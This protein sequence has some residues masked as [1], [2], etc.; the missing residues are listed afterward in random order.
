MW[1]QKE[2]SLEI[3]TAMNMKIPCLKIWGEFGRD[4]T[5][6]VYWIVLWA[7]LTFLEAC[8][9]SYPNWLDHLIMLSQRHS[10]L[11]KD[12]VSDGNGEKKITLV[13]YAGKTPDIH[14]SN[15]PTGTDY[16]SSSTSFTLIW[17]NEWFQLVVVPLMRITFV[18]YIKKTKEI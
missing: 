3:S 6:A 13:Y 15:T 18:I 9:I 8:I 10:K 2:C 7:S 14:W 5:S 16:V 11:Q 4:N 12:L 17:F 1:R